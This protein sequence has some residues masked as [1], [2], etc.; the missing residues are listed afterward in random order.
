MATK[1]SV[2]QIGIAGTTASSTNELYANNRQQCKVVINILKV[3]WD[4]SSWQKTNLTQSEINSLTVLP[5]SAA[6]FPPQAPGWS[7]DTAANSYTSGLRRSALSF[8][9]S[10]PSST[11]ETVRQVASRSTAND[12]PEVFYRYMRSATTQRQDFM[13]CVTLDDGTKYSTHYDNG[14]ERYES[15]IGI[16]P[17][18]PYALRVADLASSRQDAYQV[19]Y[20]KNKWID[21][22]TYYWT[23][24]S[25]LWIHGESFSGAGWTTD[26][27]EFAYGKR[28]DN[29]L[30][31]GMAIKVG[32]TSL[33]VGEIDGQV[34]SNYAPNQVPLINANTVMRGAR[35]SNENTNNGANYDYRLYWTVIDNFG[36]ESRF[37]LI[38]NTADKGDTLTLLDA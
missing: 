38:A 12:A 5:Y 4:G 25:G 9:Q 16:Q 28:V 17:Q 15:V 20:E 18:A 19:E 34:A 23:L 30:R 31:L 8:E 22:D 32:V 35:Y 21:V 14:D 27:L 13:A 36:C 7:C 37:V 29:V 1:L 2:F 26:K 33:T 24:P 10:G 11:A 6:L 3:T